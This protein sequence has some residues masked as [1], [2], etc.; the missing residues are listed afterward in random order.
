MTQPT[1]ACETCR[2]AELTPVQRAVDWVRFLA[3]SSPRLV[4]TL[5]Q[6]M[7]VNMAA[8]AGVPARTWYDRHREAYEQ[9][10]EAIEL[11]RM[12]RHIA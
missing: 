9:T 11:Q 10:G 2:R 3:G 6:S 8:F 1:T 12:E 4:P 5:M 7:A